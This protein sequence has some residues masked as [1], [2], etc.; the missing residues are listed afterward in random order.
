MRERLRLDC[1]M[2]AIII[3]MPGY[4]LAQGAGV[5]QSEAQALSAPAPV[6]DASVVQY[7]T[8]RGWR[9]DFLANPG[10][11]NAVPT[12]ALSSALP[13]LAQD[14]P[15]QGPRPVAFEY[16]DAYQHAAQDPR[17]REHRDAAA[18]RDA[19]S[20][21]ATACTPTPRTA[22]GRRTRWSAA[23]SACSSASIP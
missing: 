22:S 23:V 14:P 16:S 11:T 18:L 20:P 15:A 19:V 1:L 10:T 6:Q 8:G 21:S 12:F 13:A 9:V 7:A 5:A 17:L 2:L 4:A 3:L